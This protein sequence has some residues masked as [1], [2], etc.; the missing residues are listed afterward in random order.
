MAFNF[1]G[2]M[3]GV[4]DAAVSR[5]EKVE[6]EKIRIAREKRDEERQMRSIGTRQRMAREEERRKKQALLDESAGMLAMLGY[7]ED[8]INAILAKGTAATEFAITAGTESMKK[9]IDSNTIFNLGTNE[10][11]ETNKDVIN[12]TIDIA[13]PSRV[14]DITATSTA[15]PELPRDTGSGVINLDVFQ[16]VFAEPEKIESSFSAR[17]AVISQ[18]LARNPNRKDAAALK[19][20][21]TKILEDLRT[22]K[23]AEREKK[24]NNTPSFRPE[25]IRLMEK[26]V[27]NAEYRQFGFKLNM[28][29]EIENMD[30]G[31]IHLSYIAG[32]N[33]A[34]TLNGRNQGI[35]DD[36]LGIVINQVRDD[37][38]NNLTQYGYQAMYNESEKF[39]I[40]TDFNTFQQKYEARQYS[41]GDVVKFENSLFVYTNAVDHLTGMRF[42]KIADNLG[43]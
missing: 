32:I 29:D 40:E 4:A 17:L 33:I 23:E 25:D 10:A 21:Q 35:N 12:E 43:M 28:N 2:F 11:G 34:R 41:V 36:R 38:I 13:K 42:V 6:N 1:G 16:N 14:G 7:T 3:A 37:A 15:V 18:K 9:G 39:M 19:S 26:E 22:M 31:N 20:E 8:N 27:R 5:M 30:D 24:G